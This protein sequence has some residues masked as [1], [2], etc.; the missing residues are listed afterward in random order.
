MCPQL[1]CMTYAK[2]EITT[3]LH[4]HSCLSGEMINTK[5]EFVELLNLPIILIFCAILCDYSP[6]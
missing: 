5:L 3:N 2:T 4:R 1:Y 6:K